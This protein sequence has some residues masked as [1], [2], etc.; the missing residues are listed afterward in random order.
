MRALRAR[1]SE[2]DVHA[3]SSSFLAALAAIPE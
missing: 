2:Y 1:V 3:W